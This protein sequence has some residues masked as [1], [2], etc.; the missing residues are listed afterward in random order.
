MSNGAY[1]RND[2]D[3]GLSGL[4]RYFMIELVDRVFVDVE[5]YDL[6][7]LSRKQLTHK[8]AAN[9]A[10][11][12][13]NEHGSALEIGADKTLVKGHLFACEKVGHLHIANGN[14]TE[15]LLGNI[16]YFFRKSEYLAAR[17]HAQIVHAALL[18]LRS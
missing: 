14:L 11:T 7:R 17:L 8:L 18:L 2:L 6:G 13:R 5:E 12:T 16:L 9:R 3:P 4:P 1:F 10:T 15:L